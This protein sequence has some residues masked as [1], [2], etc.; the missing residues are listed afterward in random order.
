MPL[1]SFD[2]HKPFAKKVMKIAKNMTEKLS[3]S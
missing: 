1:K 3:L 2:I